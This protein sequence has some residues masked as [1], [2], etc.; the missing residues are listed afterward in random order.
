MGVFLKEMCYQLTVCVSTCI[1][2]CTSDL[3][4]YTCACVCVGTCVDDLSCTCI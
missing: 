4:V 2:V 1:F 3:F